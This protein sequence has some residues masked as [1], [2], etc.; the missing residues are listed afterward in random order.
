MLCYGPLPSL[1]LR[2]KIASFAFLFV[3]V[4]E[5]LLYVYSAGI[6]VVTANIKPHESFAQ[7]YF[8]TVYDGFFDIFNYAHWKAIYV[9][10]VALVTTFLWQFCDLF[11]VL[12]TSSLAERFRQINKYILEHKVLSEAEWRTIRKQYN[13]L[14]ILSNLFNAN[15]SGVIMLSFSANVYFISISLFQILNSRTTF[16]MFFVLF[17][18][19]FI[20]THF[21]LVSMYSAWVYEESNAVISEI[22][23]LP[24]K[25]INHEVDRLLTQ[26]A[27]RDIG[28]W[29]G[30]LF[31]VTRT[32][33]FTV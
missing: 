2:F 11:L 30:G 18:V 17:N 20:M 27:E 23:S 14:S 21:L 16:E 13:K 12:M 25:N 26:M 5:H 7:V 33:V 6:R 19:L 15:L 28:V 24:L 4:F 8:V 31:Q 9:E 32:I 22:S 3:G 29:G 10:F 1:K